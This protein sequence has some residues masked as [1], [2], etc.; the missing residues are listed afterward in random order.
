VEL[1]AVQEPTEQVETPNLIFEFLSEKHLDLL[2][3]FECPDEPSVAKFLRNDAY[4]LDNQGMTRTRLYFD[5]R[6]NFVGFFTLF[7][8]TTCIDHGKM[9]ENGFAVPD[10]FRLEFPTLTLYYIGVDSRHRGEKIGR[11]LFLDVLDICE[12]VSRNSGCRF[13][14]I[15]ALEDSKWFY[16]HYDLITI[17]CK[18]ELDEDFSHYKLYTMALPLY[19]IDENTCVEEKS[20]EGVA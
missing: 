1:K 15:E 2:H 20:T 3:S 13:L 17:D 5:E 14:M 11:K 9:I 16:D 8:S 12:Y 19:E 10:E 7:V 6:N 18:T 4:R